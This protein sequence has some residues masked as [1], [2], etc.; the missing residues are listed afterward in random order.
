VNKEK[1]RVK[2]EEKLHEFEDDET[3]KSVLNEISLFERFNIHKKKVD[4]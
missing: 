2:R 1:N 4:N 3:S